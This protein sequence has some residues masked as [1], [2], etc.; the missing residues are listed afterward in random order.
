[1]FY[2]KHSVDRVPF[3][4]IGTLPPP[5]PQASACVSSPF[6]SGKGTQPHTRLRERWGV[7]IRTRG[8]TLWLIRYIC[9]IVFFSAY[10]FLPQMTFNC[11]KIGAYFSV[12]SL[13]CGTERINSS[14]HSITDILPCFFRFCSGDFLN[15]RFS[16]P[17]L[18]VF[19][20]WLTTCWAVCRPGVRDAG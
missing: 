14:L 20:F 18:S 4:R 16:Y 1:M 3:V 6:G 5:H 19:I 8:Q 7:P 13:Y 2:E 17:V 15:S 10:Y 9:S 11:P 12:L